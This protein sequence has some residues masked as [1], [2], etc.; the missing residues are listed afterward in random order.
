VKSAE[1]SDFLNSSP[2]KR[3][4]ISFCKGFREHTEKN[5]QNQIFLRRKKMSFCGLTLLSEH[6]SFIPVA[7]T[8]LRE[9]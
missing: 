8:N 4:K 6:F 2:V 1:T 3:K 5:Q 7:L 9:N